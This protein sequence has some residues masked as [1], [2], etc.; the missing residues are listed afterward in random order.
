MTEYK[1]SEKYRSVKTNHGSLWH[2]FRTVLDDYGE[3]RYVKKICWTTD[4]GVR[5]ALPEPTTDSAG[6]YT[7][8]IQLNE[9]EIRYLWIRHFA[10]YGPSLDQLVKCK[11]QKY[12]I[13]EKRRRVQTEH[14]NLS[15]YWGSE[16]E[17]SV[18]PLCYTTHKAEEML[19]KPTTIRAE[20]ARPGSHIFK[21][22]L[23]NGPAYFCL[24]PKNETA[25]YGQDVEALE[26]CSLLKVDVMR[27]GGSMSVQSEHGNL[28]V[29][30][31][32]DRV[33]G[34]RL[35]WQATYQIDKFEGP[36]RGPTPY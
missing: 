34:E 23:D 12:K 27:D 32:Q 7:Y 28:I 13:T 9:E 8:E 30:S 17:D 33:A 16:P 11:V 3:F 35:E 6:G 36:L 18:R 22:Q 29:P 19:E 14:G 31:P 5:I 4:Y 20:V 1:V 2:C 24:A 26:K 15:H 25:F 21:I 10:S